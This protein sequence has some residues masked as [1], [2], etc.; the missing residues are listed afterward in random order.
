LERY[1]TDAQVQLHVRALLDWELALEAAQI[2]VQ[3]HD[4]I[5]AL[6]GQVSS[7]LQRWA[8]EH[9]AQ[10]VSGVRSVTSEI[11]VVLPGSSRHGDADIARAA[12]TML[13]WITL[14]PTGCI[15][16]TAVDGWITLSGS[17]RWDYQ[18][19]AA[20]AAVRY[21]V[22]ATGVTDLISV[23]AGAGEPW[24]ADR[25]EVDLALN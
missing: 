6:N 8:A 7:C 16:A 3:V 20:A 11:G 12:Q 23:G 1:P 15:Q 21:V 24:H 22:G 13:Q 5:V 2:D 10:R 25:S 17:V 19:Q 4:G 18:K 9:A 14:L